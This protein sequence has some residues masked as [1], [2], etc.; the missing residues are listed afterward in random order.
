MQWRFGTGI[1]V[2]RIWAAAGG[3]AY[4]VPDDAKY[5]CSGPC[6]HTVSRWIWKPTF[7]GA[8]RPESPIAQV[9]EDVPPHH[10]FL[11]GPERY[12]TMVPTS[13]ALIQPRRRA[14]R[15]RVRAVRRA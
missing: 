4:V 1:D 12:P 3:R 7:D 13:A 2:L 9:L 14:E 10:R 6:S 15:P 8:M 11:I 5:L